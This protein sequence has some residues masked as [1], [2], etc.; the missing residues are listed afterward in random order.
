MKWNVPNPENVILLI[1]RR[2]VIIGNFLVRETIL[3]FL[4]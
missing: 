3:P 4:Y 1:R 2:C